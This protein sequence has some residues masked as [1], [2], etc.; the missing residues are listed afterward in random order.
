[1]EIYLIRHTEVHNPEKL[2][3]GQSN[4]PLLAAWEHHFDALQQ[5]LG[6]QTSKAVFYSSPYERCTQLAGFLSA[7]NFETDQRLAEMHFGD[8]EQRPWAAINQ[9]DLNLWMENYVHFKV[10]GGESFESMHQRCCLF[11]DGLLLKNHPKVFIITHGG[12]IRSLLA[13]ILNIPL[14]KVFGLAI[15]YSSV[16]KISIDKQHNNMYQRVHYINR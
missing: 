5:K 6:Q 8:W 13:Y 2:C 9:P 3:Y 14:D 12:V 15:D 7:G 11:W 1:M 4:I 16:T 10:P